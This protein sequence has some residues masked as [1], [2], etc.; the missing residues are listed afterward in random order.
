MSLT[1]IAPEVVPPLDRAT[2]SCL[3][4]KQVK[5]ATITIGQAVPFACLLR[6]VPCCVVSTGF[7]V[8]APDSGAIWSAGLATKQ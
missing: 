4:V 3:W 8:L 5:Q 6:A 7:A 2:T 1:S